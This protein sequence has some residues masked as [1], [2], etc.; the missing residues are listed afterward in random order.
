MP[1]TRD[2]NVPPHLMTVRRGD[3][4]FLYY[5]RGGF[6]WSLPQPIGSRAFLEEYGRIHNAYGTLP[7][8]PSAA[9]IGTVEAAVREYLECAD[10]RQLAA[11]TQENYRLILDGFRTAFG[12]LQLSGLD[13]TWW[14]NYRSKHL[15]MANTWN[16]LRSLMRLVLRRYRTHHP[17]H[18][19][20]NPLDTVR[21]LNVQKSSQNRPWPKEVLV[22]VMRAA[23][24]Q[25]RALLVGYLLTS[26]RGGDVTTWLRRQ[27][28]AQMRTLT[29]QQGKTKTSLVLHVPDWLANAFGSGAPDERLF[30]TPRGQAWTITNAQDTLRVLLLNLKLARYTLHGLRATGPVALRLLG[31]DNRQIMKLTGHNT[32]AALEIYLRG[33]AG[34]TTVRL[35]QEKL[36]DIFGP[37]LEEALVGANMGR[38]AGATGRPRK[39]LQTALKTANSEA[40]KNPKKLVKPEW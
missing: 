32:E 9:K 21:R 8:K 6:T 28:D 4:T 27:Y 1:S 7:A 23:T 22:A 15:E 29:M 39:A 10:Y 17:G 25:F 18:L 30:T 11:T 16:A 19:A 12:P 34:Y 24:P 33:A 13:I 20:E 36:E 31:F 2:E 38:A 5:R 3:R 40:K 26:Q 14:E 37:M 35:A